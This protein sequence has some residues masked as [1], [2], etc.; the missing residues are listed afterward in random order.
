M[1]L[2]ALQNTSCVSVHYDC[3]N[4]WLFADWHGALTL[5]LVQ[6]GCRTIAECF[7]QHPCPRILNS[8][9]AVTSLSNDV[10]QWL[11]Y[12]YLP[13]LSAAG[14]AYLAWVSPLRL[15]SQHLIAESGS[16]DNALEL[17]IFDNLTDGYA[18]LR[19][20]HFRHL[21]DPSVGS[22]NEK[23]LQLTQRV[24]A[25]SPEPAP[26]REP[27]QPVPGWPLGCKVAPARPN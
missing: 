15:L 25:L 24:A 22:P 23:R 12:D 4:D 6:A 7:L 2:Q 14:I 9:D 18:W 16:R 3:S 20:S 26:P 21:D 17:A 11:A 27:A 1:H 8:N 19:D 10:P 13:Y 5:P